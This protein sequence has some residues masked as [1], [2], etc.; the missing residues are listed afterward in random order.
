MCFH[1]IWE[2]DSDLIDFRLIFSALSDGDARVVSAGLC[3]VEDF[4]FIWKFETI[5]VKQAVITVLKQ[6]FDGRLICGG[7]L[8]AQGVLFC[9]VCF[10]G[11]K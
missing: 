5:S 7:R 1:R 8:L 2:L 4:V 10:F 3:C 11:G 6:C 9:F